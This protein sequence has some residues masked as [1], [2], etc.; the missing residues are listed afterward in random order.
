MTND[1]LTCMEFCIQMEEIDYTFVP[2]ICHLFNSN[3]TTMF[4]QLDR[5]YY[6]ERGTHPQIRLPRFISAPKCYLCKL[7]INQFHWFYHSLC[8]ACGSKSFELRH[9]KIDLSGYRA[10][11]TGA[12]LKLGYQIALKLLRFGAEVLVT[13]RKWSNLLDNY[14]RE[15]D[16]GDWKHRLHIAKINF[17]LIHI[18]QLLP[19]F[20]SIL[21]EIWGM[22]SHI[23]IMV[24][25][26]AQT[27]SDVGENKGC[28]QVRESVLLIQMI[29]SI[30]SPIQQ[31]IHL[32]HGLQ[33]HIRQL[34]N[35]L[36][37]WI[38]DKLIH[39]RQNS[40]MLIT[41]KLNKFYW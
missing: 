23:D 1:L 10:I 28:S 34:I 32:F 6:D 16:Y 17:D 3:D 31:D 5:K 7:S 8:P 35:I 2:K 24:H 30:R 12:R 25:N 36:E 40:V 29:V 27:I 41:K 22:N 26:A 37:H 19:H 18:D 21:D 38:E 39:G 13:S 14:E 15:P 9:L 4:S 11:V 20:T 33:T